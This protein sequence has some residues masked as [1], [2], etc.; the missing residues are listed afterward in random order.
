MRAAIRPAI[1]LLLAVHTATAQGSRQSAFTADDA[2]DVV[3]YRVIDLTDDGRWLAAASATRR[4]SLGV[5]YRRDGDPTYIR[6]GSAH[7]WAAD[8]RSGEQIAV[9]PDARNVR[10]AAWSPDASRL[11]ILVLRGDRFEPVIWDR[12]SRRART[13]RVPAGFYVAENADVQWTRDGKRIVVALRSEA[14]KARATAEFER[15]TRG[16]IFVQDGREPFLA[17]D[18]MRRMGNVRSLHAIDVATGKA[19]QLLPEMMVAQ[20]AISEDDSLLT[21]QEDI[22]KKTDYDVI[23][24]T[25]NKLLA[26]GLDSGRT[27]TLQPTLKGITLSWAVDGRRYAYSREGRVYVT[28][29]GDST[30]RMIAGADTGRADADT[31][32]AVRS[33]RANQR[34][35]VVRWSPRADA[36]LLS[37]RQGLWLADVASGSRE[38]ILAVD[39]SLP[40]SPRYSTIG[41]SDD[42]RFIYMTYASRTKWER[43]LV[44]FDRTSKALQELV[45]DDRLYQGFRLS[46]RGRARVHL[47]RGKQALR[48]VRG[49]RI[50]AERTPAGRRQHEPCRQGA[51]AHQA[52][53]LSR[54]R[55]KDPLRCGL[56]ASGLRGRPE[57][58]HPV[59]RLRAVLRR[60]LRCD[61][62]RAHFGRL[63]RCEAVGRLRHRIPG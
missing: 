10:S 46:A 14:W 26:R 15:L 6:P 7:L 56:S 28:Q 29:V 36:L 57:V 38:L 24:G 9:F 54:R 23:F 20:Y 13:L 17:W 27:V 52:A 39:D 30:P 5:D 35:S 4:A 60:H 21:W 31:S 55:R 2:L 59:Q 48:P 58:P 61:R 40:T 44:R 63:C 43:G 42:G 34:F 51:R 11:A 3:N 16:P 12:E 18:A 19:T 33:A 22:T 49:G 50:D 1:I 25:E 37:N 41:W 8:T 32:A 62:Q 45:K 53:E 47:R